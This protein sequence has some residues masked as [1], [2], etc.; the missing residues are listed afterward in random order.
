MSGN[1]SR[2]ND[3]N[4]ESQPS[5]SDFKAS[6]SSIGDTAMWTGETVREIT[7]GRASGAAP[8]RSIGKLLG[9]YQVTNLLGKGGMGVVLRT[10]KP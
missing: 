2:E 1:I 3:R 9:R 6:E 8:N 4:A 10:R 7:S 5:D